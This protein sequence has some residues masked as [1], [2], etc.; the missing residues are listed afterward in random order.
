[1]RFIS[2]LCV[3]LMITMPLLVIPTPA[4][5]PL[6]QPP[7][8]TVYCV[9]TASTDAYTCAP[10]T[11]VVGWSTMPPTH[12]RLKPKTTNFG[13]ATLAISGLPP[14]AIKKV[15]VGA[16]VD[17]ND[18]DLIANQWYDLLYDGTH[19]QILGAFTGNGSDLS[20]IR[21]A[22]SSASGPL[23]YDNVNGVFSLPRASA[24]QDGYMGATDFQSLVGKLDMTAAQSGSPTACVTAGTATAYT[25]TP[26][27]AIAAY[28]AGMALTLTP[29]VS[30]GDGPVTLIVNSLTQKALKKVRNG[31]KVDLEKGDLTTAPVTI[32]FDGTDWIVY[33]TDWT[34]YESGALLAYYSNQ[35]ALG[36][37]VT[38]ETYGDSTAQG[39]D[40][41]TGTTAT[42]TAAMA[43]QTAL[44]AYY[45][46][47]AATV[48]NKGVGGTS[49]ATVRS[50][51]ENYMATS[52][53]DIVT[54]NYSINDASMNSASVTP[55]QTFLDNWRWMIRTAR[56]YGKVMIVVTQNPS[57][58]STGGV[59]NA[60]TERA[61]TYAEGVRM[62]AREMNCPLV[63]QWSNYMA[64]IRAVG[65]NVALP[66]NVHP[67][68]AYYP[69]LGR[70][71]AAP[72]IGGALVDN[73]EQ[74]YITSSRAMVYGTSK[75]LLPVMPGT[76]FGT[77]ARGS[78]I[79][80]PFWATAVR[81]LYWAY[82]ISWPAT[83]STATE[84]VLDGTSLGVFTQKDAQTTLTTAIDMETL[85]APSIL[86]GP[87]ILEIRA[88]V[89]GEVASTSYLRLRRPEP[90]IYG[91][92]TTT[93]SQPAHVLTGPIAYWSP[94]LG[95]TA[96]FL[97]DLPTPLFPTGMTVSVD[98]N[99]ARGAGI[100]IAASRRNG[101]ANPASPFGGYIVYVD[102]S[103]GN[104]M[105]T[106]VADGTN[107]QNTV[108][109]ATGDKAGRHTL[110]ITAAADGTITT[111]LDGAQVDTYTMVHPFK[112]GVLGLY[113]R[114]TAPST[115][116][117][118]A[119]IR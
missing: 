108:T 115:L 24:S 30:S 42:T 5:T 57:Y 73:P 112:G 45:Q 91:Y 14:V 23:S 78:T 83:Q 37:P 97:T 74:E 99:L 19:L 2:L 110:A 81:D 66:D 56:R 43:M 47:T 31:A 89:A 13:A 90:K 54:A 118:A 86:P 59:D 102:Y 116:Y 26:T 38:I 84:L 62:I 33:P 7:D 72:I 77:T 87:H 34:A 101:G 109:L 103:T 67:T 16:K 44:R 48:V 49:T 80:I 64:V 46:N 114:N 79:V 76:L 3:L 96:N 55:F 60:P 68:A 117:S 29:H 52:T 69:V 63:D 92:T 1:M 15:L 27:P 53:A 95:G 51:W 10:T 32:R 6:P 104:L 71:L 105:R 85:V 36:N 18:G 98:V 21:Q 28:T 35:L 41:G 106:E 88:N 93:F 9:D 12:V 94:A 17:P 58:S 4:Q 20:V 107:L 119:L 65:Q 39:T 50:L 70:A 111:S 11:A 61:R 25:C 8:R 40:G 82:T 100:S 113:T 22:V 75:A